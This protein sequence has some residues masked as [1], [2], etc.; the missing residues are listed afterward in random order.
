[1]LISDTVD[2]A[3]YVVE[4]WWCT[5]SRYEFANFVV[6]VKWWCSEG[7]DMFSVN[8]W[9]FELSPI[10]KFIIHHLDDD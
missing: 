5:I 4:I 9:D 2:V 8:R 6:F 1:M 7:E 10:A 3:S